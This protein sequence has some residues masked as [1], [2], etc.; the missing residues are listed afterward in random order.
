MKTT[1]IYLGL[2][3]TSLASAQNIGIGTVSP[4][5]TLHVKTNNDYILRVR[6]AVTTTDANWTIKSADGFGTFN[7]VATGVFRS[8]VVFPLSATGVTISTVAPN[9][10]NTGIPISVP[11]GKWN[12]TG[13]LVLTPSS[14]ISS[15]TDSAY[16]CRVSLA[17]DASSTTAT[18]DFISAE[19]YSAGKGEMFGRLLGPLPKDYVSGNMFIYNPSLTNKTYYILANIERISGSSTVNFK[20]F[21]LKTTPENQLYAMPINEN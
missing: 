10:Q 17:D 2:F 18:S 4:S 1:F 3:F 11:P 19:N 14:S 21:G 9:W 16:N 7:K 12:I 15:Q 20:D 8:T 6:D 5:S 13:T